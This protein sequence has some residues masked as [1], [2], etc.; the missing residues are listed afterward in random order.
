MTR[1]FKSFHEWMQT[2]DKE[3]Y[4]TLVEFNDGPSN[5]RDFLKQAGALGAAALIGSTVGAAEKSGKLGTSS[6][7]VKKPDSWRSKKIIGKLEVD[8][9]KDDL[10]EKDYNHVV[11]L[12]EIPKEVR[13]AIFSTPNTE[14]LLGGMEY[15]YR[16][17]ILT[18]LYVKL[19]EDLD[20]PNIEPNQII[21]TLPLTRLPKERLPLSLSDDY[22]HSKAKNPFM[23]DQGETKNKIQDLNVKFEMEI[24]YW[25][26][27]TEKGKIAVPIGIQDL[28]KF[29]LKKEK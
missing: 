3:F 19:Q 23:N 16:Q 6:P 28:K 27:P 8:F 17:A 24:H 20:N 2:R 12:A 14:K 10:G 1:K 5:R 13:E 25:I 15:I 18:K 4:I 11:V 26:R 9:K 21:I 29:K 22:E 7:E